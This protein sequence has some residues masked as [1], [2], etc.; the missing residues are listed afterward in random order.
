MFAAT[1]L[2]AC[3]AP[4]VEPATSTE[5]G[6]AHSLA[7]PLPPPPPPPPPSPP[8]HAVGP[9]TAAPN[10]GAPVQPAEVD[11]ARR[12]RAF[13]VSLYRQLA[14]RPGNILIS[15]ISIA[16]AFGP[17]DAGARGYTQDDIIM[18]LNFPVVE[19]DLRE[20]LPNLLDTLET[21]GKGVQVRFANAL[22]LMKDFKVRPD[23]VDTAKYDYRANVD[24]VDFRDSPAAAAKIN[25]WVGH[26]T[27]GRIPKLFEE[28][29]FNTNTRVVVTNAAY[30]LSDWKVPFPLRKTHAAPFY[31]QDGSTREVPMMSIRMLMHS[32]KK[33]EVE[34][35][36]LPYK[37]DRLSMV[38][39]LPRSRNG[40]SAVEA[41]LS[42]ARVNEWLRLI[43]SSPPSDL[44]ISLPRME[45]ES[46]YDLIPS[47]TALGMKLP[48]IPGAA[49]FSG[50][51]DP[52]DGRSLYI[53]A[54]QHKTFLRIDE[55]GTE[56]AAGTG[57]VI[58]IERDGPAFIADHPF[59]FLIR[60][61]PT[62]AVL[63]LG[64]VSEP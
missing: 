22:W 4:V 27:N 48:F 49:D 3:A 35:A 30:F 29:A 60:D 50:I 57:V 26:E 38:V 21:D 45:I 14:T 18:T 58:S 6:A 54:V 12:V 36:E 53:S 9:Q 23:F 61:K 15:P 51:A 55:K 59:L 44:D 33:D 32:A 43:D 28:D 64:R 52:P 56:A 2:G 17:L 39:I 24:T 34:L 42:S 8:D 16:A 7:A 25:N 41:K 46:R 5:L 10:G 13:G 1:M 31:L 11:M 37:G 47:L 40:L 19:G 63:F 62:G 20:L